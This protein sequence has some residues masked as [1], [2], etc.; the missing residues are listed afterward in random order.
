[1]A[2]PEE[3]I[4]EGAHFITR[5]VHDVLRRRARAADD[6]ATITVRDIRPRL[7]AFATAL[8]GVSIPIR[9]AD[10]AAPLSWLARLAARRP[11]RVAWPAADDR[12]V[13]LPQSLDGLDADAA[14]E[15]YRLV[16]VTQAVRLMRGTS[17]LA[18]G[19]G[20]EEIR[21]RFLAAEAAVVDG[22][23]ARET[24][25]LVSILRTLQ[26]EALSERPPTQTFTRREQAVESTVRAV[27]SGD[28]AYDGPADAPASETLR[29]AVARTGT[30]HLPGRYRAVPRVWYWGYP[31]Q[32][33]MMQRHAQAAYAEPESHAV[34]PRV[35]EMLR[36]PRIREA[37]PDEDDAEQGTWIFR[38][39]EP[40]ESVED[41]FGLQR[42]ID[43]EQDAD[44]DALGD[45]LSELSE[46]RVVR[47]PEK[48]REI[49]RSGE[50][51]RTPIAER[52]R[53]A[54]AG[55]A[56]PE[57]DY[58]CSDYIEA[59]TIVREHPPGP[60]DPAWIAD[61]LRR[62]DRL[63]RRVQAVF[64]RLR[65][66]RIEI[67]RQADGPDVDV[68]SCVSA[69][70]DMR[71]GGIIDD[72]LYTASRPERRRLA[73]GLLVDVS[74]STDAW[75]SSDR[76]IVD[77]EKEA[78][79]VVCEALD[80]L[81][82]RY[83]VFAFSG[84]GPSD[85][86]VLTVKRFSEAL[87][88]AVR[89]RIAGLD[90]DRYTRLGAAIRHAAAMVAR[91]RSDRA[92]LFVLSDG[93]PNDVDLY[94]GM[95]GVEDARQAVAETRAQGTHVFCLTVDREAPQYAG[96]IFGA[97]GFALLPRAERL[98]MVLVD[99]LRRHVRR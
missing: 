19:A 21:D 44:A 68:N 72:R 35:S 88:P 42:P 48:P 96:R 24:P 40:Q 69:A 52:P 60:G 10:V 84:E 34:R 83:E 61:A 67:G 49:L 71:A 56:Y 78:L 12:C 85:V 4:I 91:E 57:W 89:E 33:S 37:A 8:C 93:K 30:T 28:G 9:E 11:P 29:W 98:L 31:T 50:T 43:R 81:G 20:S 45:S 47:T 55:I 74:A 2:E 97:S 18:F 54:V 38:A 15:R 76:R 27:L 77:V 90:A 75:I 53:P 82:D 41:P 62:H 87:G 46:A 95:Y 22:W 39:D 58:R 64:G 36:R 79:L 6:G 7:E 73:I 26:R 16:T 5:H 65:P 32:P 3:L 59:G 70:A 94:E 80:A 17:T 99:V 1:M 13:Y 66:R 86:S 51:E 25:G 23:I 92:V 14:I 63:I